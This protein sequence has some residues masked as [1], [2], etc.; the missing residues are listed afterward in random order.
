VFSSLLRCDGL[1]QGALVGGVT[2]LLFVSWIVIGA[3][4]EIARGAIKFPWKPMS[5]EGCTDNLTQPVDP[6]SVPDDR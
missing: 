6:L 4:T 2:S 5:T 1:F 3:Q